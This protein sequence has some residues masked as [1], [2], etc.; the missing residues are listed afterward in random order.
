MAEF[1]ELTEILKHLLTN[2]FAPKPSFIRGLLGDGTG[3]VN[4]PNRDDYH[5]ARFSRGASESFEVFNKETPAID[6]WPVLIGELPWLPGLT[7]VVGT[8]WASYEAAGWG[9]AAGGLVL[10]APIHEWRDGSVGADPMSVYLRS[11]A[12]LRAYA[13][14]SGTTEI[15]VNAYE[16]D[17]SGTV[18][19]GTPSI[20]VSAPMLALTTGNA[21]FL[22]IY[23]DPNNNTLGIVTGATSV[24]TPAFDPPRVSFPVGVIPSARIKI[25]GGQGALSE[26]DF[27]DARR[28]F[29]PF[30]TGTSTK[31]AAGGDL[32][33]TYP[34]PQ[35]VGLAGTV[36]ENT[37]P[38]EGDILMVSGSAWIPLPLPVSGWPFTNVLTVSTTDPDADFPAPQ[39]AIDASSPGDVILLD[40]EQAD[41]GMVITSAITIQGVGE[42]DSKIRVGDLSEVLI[43]GT[44]A[45]LV[46]L[47]IEDT[48][49][50]FLSN[51]GKVQTDCV[52]R[53]CRIANNA[54][55]TTVGL[56]VDNGATA[57]LENCDIEATT[58]GSFALLTGSAGTKVEV[59]GGTYNAPV[60]DIDVAVSTTVEFLAEPSLLGGGLTN[61][62]TTQ[63]WY[64]D[65][66]G[67][68]ISAGGDLDLNGQVDG[69]VLSAGGGETISAPTPGQIDFEAGGGDRINLTA[70]NM[71]MAVPVDLNGQ[72]DALILSAGGGE[73]ISAPTPGQIDFEAGS[74]DRMTLTAS[75]LAVAAG[76]RVKEFSTDATLG[77]ASYATTLISSAW[78]KLATTTLGAA[79]QI[80]FSS[81]PSIYQALVIIGFA[82]SADTVN[83]NDTLGIQCNGDAGG[84]YS[85]GVIFSVGLGA[86]TPGANLGVT[87]ARAAAIETSRAGVAAGEF[88]SIFIVLPNYTSTSEHKDFVSPPG[89]LRAN[90]VAGNTL[91]E[92]RKPKWHNGTIAAITSLKFL[93]I[94]DASNNMK[95]GSKLILYGVF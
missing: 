81:I 17:P 57:R 4:V 35:V 37:T 75:G 40:A 60:S 27:R 69:L 11:I 31:G 8:D 46:N 48:I 24:F 93:T 87:A 49:G 30:A 50:G 32:T 39:D 70:T 22:G 89:F 72:V 19:P 51:A 38:N 13:V 62:G 91:V 36:L 76:P 10:H 90:G 92:F 7:Q 82:K 20:N 54:T 59:L 85:N 83:W 95:A 21:Q 6:N 53:N 2:M 33:G 58:T 3:V 15:F 88:T 28:P 9:E 34:N 65:S 41:G 71:L 45:A 63:G 52:I 5:F 26:T 68:Q 18:W 43:S 16:Y 23:L 74:S 79:G 66:N 78:V 14:G 73:T 67:N 29:A 86:V 12:P 25:H 55:L 61:A 84:N 64:I 56:L 80:T 42:R 77:A 94:F 1:D 47:D 44:G